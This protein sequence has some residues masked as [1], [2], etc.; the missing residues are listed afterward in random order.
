MIPFAH[1]L[2]SG[3]KALFRRKKNFSNIKIFSFYCFCKPL[4]NEINKMT[5]KNPP[6]KPTGFE[7]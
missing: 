2:N 3:T 6:L 7:N 1:N 5:E 4:P